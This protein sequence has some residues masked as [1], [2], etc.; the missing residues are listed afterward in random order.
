MVQRQYSVVLIKDKIKGDA[1]A[2]PS[3]QIFRGHTA[4]LNCL[5]YDEQKQVLYT[6]GGDG[7]IRSWNLMSGEAMKILRGHEGPI[8]CLLI[9]KRML[10]SGSSDKSARSWVLEFGECTR[11]YSGH[12]HTVSSIRHFDGMCKHYTY[13]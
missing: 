11:V 4:P 13:F 1:F 9:H 5:A 12:R 10:Y 3:S 7:L 2:A 8:F 6:A